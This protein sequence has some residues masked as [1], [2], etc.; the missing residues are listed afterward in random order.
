[1]PKC[2]F[3]NEP[4]CGRQRAQHEA[5]RAI[6][7]LYNLLAARPIESAQWATQC[8][9]VDRAEKPSRHLTEHAKRRLHHTVADRGLA[10]PSRVTVRISSIPSRML[11]AMPGASRSSCL[12]RLRISLSALSASI[13]LFPTPLCLPQ[14]A[15]RSDPLSLLGPGK[16]SENR[17]RVLRSL[18]GCRRARA[19]RCSTASGPAPS[20]AAASAAASF[21]LRW[22]SFILVKHV[23][24]FGRFV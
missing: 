14:P 18:P 22:F 19:A 5:F 2:N 4:G 15:S 7:G 24:D 21:R 12:A 11:A 17:T 13:A 1:V 8:L 23:R 3:F 10:N 9:I 6:P 20:A 16:A